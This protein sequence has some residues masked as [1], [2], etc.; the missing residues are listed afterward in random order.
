MTKYIPI[1]LVVLIFV[2]YSSSMHG[3]FVFD[4]QQI[5]LQNSGLLH[6]KTFRDTLEFGGGWRQ[7]L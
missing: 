1:V 4:D 7:L 3:D 2:A 6:I 5:V